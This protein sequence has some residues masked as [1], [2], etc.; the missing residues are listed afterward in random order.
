MNFLNLIN[1]YFLANWLPTIATS[2]GMTAS[3]AVLLG[4]TLQ[5]GGVVG[6]IVMGPVIDR[7]GF[8]RVLVPVFLAAGVAIALIGRPGMSVTA[9]FA[10][11]G[12]AGSALSAASPR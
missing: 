1:L 4:T 8:R 11:V 3:R 2:A 6:T 12:V 5:V 10:V 9:L 7:V